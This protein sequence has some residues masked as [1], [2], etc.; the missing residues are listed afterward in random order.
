MHPEA[1]W[2]AARKYPVHEM[3]LSNRK[4]VANAFLRNDTRNT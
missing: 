3:C 2:Q 1:D 4:G